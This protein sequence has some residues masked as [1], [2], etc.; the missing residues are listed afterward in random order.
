MRV[1][2]KESLIDF[3]D[4]ELLEAYLSSIKSAQSG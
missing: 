4:D 2:K 3:T 1:D